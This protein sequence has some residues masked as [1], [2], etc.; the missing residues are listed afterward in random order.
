MVVIIA[1]FLLSET[2]VIEILTSLESNPLDNVLAAHSLHVYLRFGLT[3][4]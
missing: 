2:R 4:V 3:K 1:S